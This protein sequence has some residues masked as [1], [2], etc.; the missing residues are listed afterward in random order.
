[1]V[2]PLAS[3]FA[4]AVGRK[5]LEM[6]ANGQAKN[7]RRLRQF[8]PEA[9]DIMRQVLAR[10]Q[11]ECLPLFVEELGLARAGEGAEEED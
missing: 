8:E 1:M 7:R 10:P 5:E 6:L 9:H 4:L 2:I 3:H 11:R